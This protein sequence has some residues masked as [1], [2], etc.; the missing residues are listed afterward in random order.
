MFLT[1]IF[2]EIHIDVVSDVTQ[3]RII[4]DAIL[5]VPMYVSDN[6]GDISTWTYY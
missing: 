6:S 2:S 3:T 1:P 4:T 5:R